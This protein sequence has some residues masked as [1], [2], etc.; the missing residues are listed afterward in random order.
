MT[1]ITDKKWR[2]NGQGR[3]GRGRESKQGEWGK[4]VTVWAL[5]LEFAHVDGDGLTVT[6]FTLTKAGFHLNSHQWEKGEEMNHG[7]SELWKY[8]TMYQNAVGFICQWCRLWCPVKRER[9]ATDKCVLQDP[10]FAKTTSPKPKDY[11]CTHLCIF[12]WAK[13][14]EG[15]T[16]TRLR[17]RKGRW[18]R[19]GRGDEFFLFTCSHCVTE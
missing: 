13:E 18:K 6:W 9:Q 2:G 16:P 1:E 5:S 17:H 11:L 8:S 19:D 12:M 7:T 4:E 10:S 15:C 14:E 3:I